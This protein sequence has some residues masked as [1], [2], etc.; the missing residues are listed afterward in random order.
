M[1]NEARTLA[2][3]YADIRASGINEERRD[4]LF[5]AAH[6]IKGQAGTLGYPLVGEVAASLCFLIER[7]PVS[8]LPL[9]LVGQHVDAVRAMVAETAKSEDN[10]TARALIDRLGDVTDDFV[11]R[12]GLPE[13]D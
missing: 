11:A 6:D 2:E 12:H 5:R 1:A 9:T 13:A 10:A 3:A 8:T 4:S 7:V